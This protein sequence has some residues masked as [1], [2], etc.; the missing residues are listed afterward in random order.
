MEDEKKEIQSRIDYCS[1]LIA[2]QQSLA[3]ELG[4]YIEQTNSAIDKARM[5]I[6]R[7]ELLQKIKYQSTVQKDWENR[8][9]N[10]EAQFE[11]ESKECNENFDKVLEMAKRLTN[12][13]RIQNLN[14]AIDKNGYFDQNEKN[15]YYKTF[16]NEFANAKI[17]FR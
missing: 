4:K 15:K 14:S 11:A 2:A 6:E 1:E 10:H 17:K 5:Q 16:L 8:L 9:H 3:D 13:P 12:Y 7:L